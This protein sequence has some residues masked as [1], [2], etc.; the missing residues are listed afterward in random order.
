MANLLLE[1]AVAWN[2]MRKGLVSDIKSNSKRAIT[3]T[4]LEN[5]RREILREHATAGATNAA[6][7]AIINKVM[8]PLIK[9]VMPTVMAHELV[10]VQPLTGPSGTITTMRIRYATTSPVDG[11]GII[12]GQEAM[13]PFL[14][15]AW[16]SGNE[17]MDHP[18]A[19][20]TAVLEGVGGNDI[21]IEFVK[22]DVKA[23]SRK[24]KARFTLEA[25]Q[26]AE[27]QYGA[28]VEQELT[29]ALAQ[30]IVL[31]IDQEI[32]AR[33]RSIAGLSVATYDQNKI[34]GVATSVV[35][36]HAALAVMINRY[37]NE[38]A[39]KIRK[40]SA[41]WAVV[42]HEVLSVLQSATASQFVRT[43]EGTFEAPTNN[44]F[45]GTLNGT[46]K[47]YVNTYAT[48][49][50][51]LI[52]YKGS[53][54]IDAA[55]YY[56]P[57]VPVMCSGTI[58]DPNTFEHVMAMSTRYGF[59]ALTNPANSLGNAADYLARIKVENLRFI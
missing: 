9:R 46:L 11:S 56:C 54:E 55:A 41:N 23:G 20:D 37:S 53:D 1:N 12:A 21:S 13:S 59:F 42:S 24:L 4:V 19:A 29:S 52:G 22:E 8:M 16:Y 31:D 49:N 6:N 25:M 51:I 44:K 40:A 3:E 48:D 58:L 28:N 32:L 17:D 47:V 2:K 14:V 43:T 27:S 36:E 39:R 57:Y 15:G 33:L 34:S 18:A 7:V 26:D 45:V 50:D 10:G 30:Q 35:D 38:I 5:S